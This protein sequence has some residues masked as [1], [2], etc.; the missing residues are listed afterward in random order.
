MSGRSS[1]AV[2]RGPLAPMVQEPINI[3]TSA[4]RGHLDKSK[5]SMPDIHCFGLDQ[6]PGPV[7]K[8]RVIGV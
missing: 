8:A 6:A 7:T 2:S 5:T 3:V 1:Q 4:S